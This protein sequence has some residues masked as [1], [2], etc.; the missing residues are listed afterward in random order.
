MKH[1]QGGEVRS[2]ER[3]MS[4]KLTMDQVE[5]EAMIDTFGSEPRRWPESRRAGAEA[6]L[7]ASAAARTSLAEARAL[8]QV[9]GTAPTVDA[10]RMQA[11]AARIVANARQDTAD[12]AAEPSGAATGGNVVRFDA[13]ARQGRVSTG[14]PMVP[15]AAPRRARWQ[16]GGLLAAS[17]ALGL[18]IGSVGPVPGTMPSL[19]EP[20][21]DGTVEQIIA[22]IDGDGLTVVLD[23]DA[24]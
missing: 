23:E 9:L 18:A 19:L 8:D 12:R 13:V 2:L 10:D 15:A 17:L 3:Q 20:D 21:R 4:G 7:Q 22:A 14:R 24:L 5:F 11:L 16:V 1:R 6:L